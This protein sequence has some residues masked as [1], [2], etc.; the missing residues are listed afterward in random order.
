MENGIEYINYKD[1]V[2]LTSVDLSFCFS[3]PVHFL[4][5]DEKYRVV[6]TDEIVEVVWP[7]EDRTMHQQLHVGAVMSQEHWDNVRLAIQKACESLTAA[8][9]AAA[10]HTY[11]L[12]TK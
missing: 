1:R 8:R 12:P 11:K 9:R 5:D 4:L 2:V 3:S 10:S 6:K 7:G